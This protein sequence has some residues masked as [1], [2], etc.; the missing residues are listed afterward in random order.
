MTNEAARI[1]GQQW[2]MRRCYDRPDELVTTTEASSEDDIPE[3]LMT[4]TDASEEKG[5]EKTRLSERL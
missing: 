2:S 5:E 3:Y 1:Q 4:T